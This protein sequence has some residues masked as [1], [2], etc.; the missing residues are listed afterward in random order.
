M[1]L[2]LN[3]WYDHIVLS[4]TARTFL[5][6]KWV[7]KMINGII[8]CTTGCVN[9]QCP[10][11]SSTHSFGNNKSPTYPLV[12]FDTGCIKQTEMFIPQKT[13]IQ[14]GQCLEGQLGLGPCLPVMEAVL[15]LH[16]RGR[17]D[18]KAPA[19][20]SASLWPHQRQGGD[21]P[22]CSL[23]SKCAISLTHYLWTFAASK[24]EAAVRKRA[25]E[26]DQLF[27]RRSSRGRRA[28]SV[29]AA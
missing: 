6:V 14:S 15:V 12:R 8:S 27:R 1:N 25:P 21:Q 26:P 24:H 13:A 3:G 23:F 11:Q 28:G 9:W 22:H 18:A 7:L 29:S 17:T 16:V 2:S 4:S 5:Q 10:V 19:S 20:R